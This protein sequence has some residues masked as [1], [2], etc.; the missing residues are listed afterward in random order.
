MI[1]RRVTRSLSK[2]VLTLSVLTFSPPLFGQAVNG[3]LLGTVTDASGATV[4]NAK[5]TARETT[6]GAIHVS[7]TNDSGN[8]T[9]PDL[10][11]GIYT[12]ETEARDFKKSAHENIELL[13]NPSIRVDLSLQACDAI[14]PVI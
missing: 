11:P 3:T 6:T 2:F 1:P 5:V 13:S 14:E 4:A 7:A 12:E 10:Q 8:Y 9:F